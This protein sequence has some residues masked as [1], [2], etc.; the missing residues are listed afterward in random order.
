MGTGGATLFTSLT[1]TPSSY[2]GKAGDVP[3]VNGSETG[4]EFLAGVNG[5]FTTVDNKT[6][7]VTNGIITSIV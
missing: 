4:I 5:S 3:V 7:T 6:V 2:V 1:D